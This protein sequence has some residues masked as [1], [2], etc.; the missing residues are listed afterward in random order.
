VHG[1]ARP[2]ETGAAAAGGR[3]D[4]ARHVERNA[5][6]GLHARAHV[7]QDD[8]RTVAF[9]VV[10]QVRQRGGQHQEHEDDDLDREGDESALLSVDA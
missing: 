1:V 4:L 5:V 3:V 10:A 9:T 6:V 7:D 8:E 2:R